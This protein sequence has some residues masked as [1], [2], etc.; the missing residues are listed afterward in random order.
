MGACAS[1]PGLGRLREEEEPAA[2]HNV[3][4][5]ED[6]YWLAAFLDPDFVRSRVSWMISCYNYTVEMNPGLQQAD[7][8]PYTGFRRECQRLF[9]DDRPGM[10]LIRFM[11]HGTPE[12]NIDGILHEGLVLT[13]LD[14][15]FFS[16]SVNNCLSFT[17]PN[18]NGVP[19]ILLFLVLIPS[20]SEKHR[21]VWTI[22][23]N[24]PHRSLPVATIHLTSSK[25]LGRSMAEST[26]GDAAAKVCDAPPPDRSENFKVDPG[27]DR[28]VRVDDSVET[29]KTENHAGAEEQEDRRGEEE[30]EEAQGKEEEG[31]EEE[32]LRELPEKMRKSVEVIHHIS[33]E[34]GL[35]STV[36]MAV[37]LEL[38]RER[39]SLLLK[40]TNGIP[41]VKQMLESWRS[42]KMNS[43]GIIYSYFLAKVSFLAAQRLEV[44]PGGEFRRAYEIGRACNALVI[45]GDRPASISLK[46][47]VARLTLWQKMKLG[48]T[49]LWSIIC[50]PGAEELEKMLTE[51]TD[52]DEF[53]KFLREYCKN[54]PTLLDAL[55][56]ERDLFMTSTL[57][58][59][60]SKYASVVAVVGKGHVSGIIANWTKPPIEVD[61]LLEVPEKKSWG[62]RWRLGSLFLVGVGLGFYIGKRWML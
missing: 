27:S 43:F 41:T 3:A 24:A 20:P 51:L 36:Y 15:F 22:S 9:G 1:I 31:E 59:A 50:L 57:R 61:A 17:K 19:K 7:Y 4:A 56:T 42:K 47:A 25:V 44:P 58:S 32:A 10:D 35:E 60:C 21:D 14:K 5:S 62:V 55:L 13:N 39:C 40:T 37:F 33:G 26:T 34:T 38:C 49:L 28:L 23:A 54:F 11:F 29:E 18:F 46:R 12:I 52:T 8:A 53:V 16:T 2:L 30:G 6:R 45:L 48:G